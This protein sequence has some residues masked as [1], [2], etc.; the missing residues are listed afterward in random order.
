[1][2]YCLVVRLLCLTIVLSIFYLRLLIT[3]H[4]PYFWFL[5][6]CSMPL[7]LFNIICI[8]HITS[9]VSR[10]LLCLMF[11]FRA[12]CLIRNMNC[13]PFASAYVHSRFILEG[14]V[15]LIF[16]V[17]CVVLY[18]NSRR[19]VS[20]VTNMLPVPLIV[21]SCLPLR[22]SLT[23]IYNTVVV[24]LLRESWYFTRIW[25][26]LAIP[27]HFTKMGGLWIV[28]V[29]PGM[30]A[31]CICI[32]EAFISTMFERNLELFC[33]CGNPVC[34]T[35]MKTIIKSEHRTQPTYEQNMKNIPSPMCSCG[36]AEQITT[37][38]L[39]TRKN[40]QELR[41][42]IWPL[43]TTLQEKLYGPVDALQKTTRFVAETE[44]Q[45]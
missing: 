35:K 5:S 3:P 20:C 11:K 1:M 10:K 31:S 41:E 43:P 34:L 40:H 25:L 4:P 26:P 13:L 28:S 19:P 30:W 36:E 42:E 9:H 27:D 22:F 7:S 33:Q 8:I 6:N 24:Q 18:F 29:K 12:T 17:F 21:N 15:L 38:I 37:H 44:I 16:L 39:Q 32:L 45:V 23:S 14:S 2:C